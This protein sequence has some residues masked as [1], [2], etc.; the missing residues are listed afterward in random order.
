MTATRGEAYAF[1][2][3]PN[4]LTAEIA[5]GILPGERV[6]AAWFDPRNGMSH[7][8][9][10]YDNKQRIKFTPPSSGRGEDWVL[11]LDSIR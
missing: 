6:L 2:Y 7:P 11:I 1:V 5:M 9:G 10:D 3:C 4:G 8:I